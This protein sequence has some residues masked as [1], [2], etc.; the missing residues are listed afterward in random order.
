MYLIFVFRNPKIWQ[1]IQL[2]VALMFYTSDI[3]IA[4]YSILLTLQRIIYRDLGKKK[5][6]LHSKGIWRVLDR[7]SFF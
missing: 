2:T 3:S 4:S 7:N 5:L 6:T 1:I